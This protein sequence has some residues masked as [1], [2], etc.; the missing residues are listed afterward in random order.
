MLD[1]GELVLAEPL[2][3]QLPRRA[4]GDLA[5]DEIDLCAGFLFG[6]CKV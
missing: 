5:A 4:R 2:E 3:E 1:Q 6:E